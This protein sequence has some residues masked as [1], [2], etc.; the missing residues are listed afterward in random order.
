[1][2]IH[3]FPILL[4]MILHDTFWSIAALL[5]ASYTPLVAGPD[6]RKHSSQSLPVLAFEGFECPLGECC[7]SFRNIAFTPEL[8]TN[9][10]PKLSRVTGRVTAEFEANGTN[11]C[12]GR[13]GLA[14]CEVTGVRQ[15]DIHGNPGFA[16]LESVRMWEGQ[17]HVLCDSRA[18]SVERH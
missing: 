3:D 14:D 12:V 2:E 7:G 11:C 4:N 17:I 18:V 8:L 9:P 1:M 5:K 13:R 6:S 15:S 10:K 16:G